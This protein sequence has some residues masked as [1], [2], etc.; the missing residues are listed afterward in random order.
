MAIYHLLHNAIRN[1]VK[2]G[3]KSGPIT[4]ELVLSGGPTEF[5]T[6]TVENEPGTNHPQMLQFEASH[7]ENWLLRNAAEDIELSNCGVGAAGS[8]FQGCR[9]M[10]KVASCMPWAPKL[11]FNATSRTCFTLPLGACVQPEGTAGAGTIADF[12]QVCML[13][14]DDQNA[15]RLQIMSAAENMGIPIQQKRDMTDLKQGVF[16]DEPNLKLFGRTPP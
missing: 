12:S 3:A 6:L 16:R 15:P 10:R 7:G 8:T 9:D 5:L 1:A 14:A 13:C 2:H 4:I 11:A